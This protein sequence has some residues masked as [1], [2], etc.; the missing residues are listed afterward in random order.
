MS[1]N[2]H[3]TKHIVWSKDDDMEEIF[4]KIYKRNLWQSSESVSGKGSEIE[5]AQNLLEKL[6]L[7]LEKY[8]IRSITDAPCGDYNWMKKLNYKFEI[9]QG[10]DIVKEIIQNNKIYENTN[11]RFD[12]ANILDCK[13][14]K[15]DLIL[16]RDCFIHFDFSEIFHC[17]NNFKQSEIE[18]L[19]LTNYDISQN[20][21]VLTGQFR[22]INLQMPPFNFPVPLEKLE[23][24]IADG[25][26]LCLWRL[27]EL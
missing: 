23:D 22:K 10:I 21:D 27:S 4:E 24:D 25:K 12:C 16:C 5:A 20:G 18:Y 14:K 7:L 6:P 11:I 2:E 8:N 26:Y 9:Y 19:L 3:I 17:I 1:L 13:L 15:T